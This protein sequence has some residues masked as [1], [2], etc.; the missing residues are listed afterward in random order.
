MSVSELNVAKTTTVSITGH[1][2]RMFLTIR[3]KYFGITP[4]EKGHP[5]MEDLIGSMIT[6]VSDLLESGYAKTS[7]YG[8]QH[9]LFNEDA[10]ISSPDYIEYL[11][12]KKEKLEKELKAIN[13]QL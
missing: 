4:H 6:F 9:F 2:R 12:W 3:E 8:D 13:D 1:S 11:L 5:T 7:K 10:R